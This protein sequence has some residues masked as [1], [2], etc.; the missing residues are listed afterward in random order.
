MAT[1]E[2]IKNELIDKILSIQD[3]ELLEALDK[4]VSS[5]TLPG[6]KGYLTDSQKSMLKLSEE[7]IKYDRLISEEDMMKRN[8]EWLDEL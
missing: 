5:A 8:R 3:K 1:E 7:D 2:E 6:G 4:L